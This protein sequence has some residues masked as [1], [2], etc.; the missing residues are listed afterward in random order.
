MANLIVAKDTF[1]VSSE[2]GKWKCCDLND[3]FLVL[4]DDTISKEYIVNT[5]EQSDFEDYE[6]NIVLN[7]QR[8]KSWCIRFSVD[9]NRE[10][11]V[12]SLLE[13]FNV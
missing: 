8:N 4:I 3:G 7:S 5:L 2:N 11:E 9:N 13:K 12:Q 1:E 10:I 6:Y